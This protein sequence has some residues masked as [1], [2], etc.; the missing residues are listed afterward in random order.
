MSSGNGRVA[1]VTGA[2]GGI[3]GVMTRALLGEGHKVLAMD[4]NE[5]ALGDLQ[6][7]TAAD[8]LH[9]FQGDVSSEADSERAV[10]E[11]VAQFGRLEI[12]I[13]NAGIGPSSVRPDA[14]KRTP[15]IEELTAAVWDRFFAVNVRGPFLLAHAALPHMKAAGWGRIVNN[16]TSFLTMHRV[17]PYGATKAALESASAIWAKELDGSG[18][19]VNVLIPGGPTDTPFIAEQSGIPRDQM[20][21]AE[22]MAAPTR[23]L[24]SDASDGFNGRRIIAAR[25][26]GE[27]PAEQT[28]QEASA[29]IA[30]PQ[31][32]A[33]VVWP[34]GA[35]A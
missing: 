31:L 2:G 8:G 3:G 12:L 35:P 6:S 13:N 10:R 11:C 4:E 29:P 5:Q 32:T 17:L 23:W 22:V 30:W 26:S 16:T 7:Q 27:V 33:D 20:L 25:W 19:T 1:L 21:Q 28:A 14:E 18:V 34:G 24:A 9:L 15:G